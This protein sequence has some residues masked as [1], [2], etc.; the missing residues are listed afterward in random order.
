VRE[1]I[2]RALVDSDRVRVSVINDVV[3]LCGSVSSSFDREELLRTAAAAAGENE[4]EDR[5]NVQR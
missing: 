4:I 2:G 5:L 1:A 3:R